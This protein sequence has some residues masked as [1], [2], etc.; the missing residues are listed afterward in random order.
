MQKLGKISKFS[1]IFPQIFERW[2]RC[3]GVH[4][5]DLGERFPKSIYLQ[6][7]PSIQPRTSPSTFGGKIQFNIIQS[8][9]KSAAS[10][11][12]LR[13]PSGLDNLETSGFDSFE[14]SARSEWGKIHSRKSQ[15]SARCGPSTCASSCAVCS[16]PILKQPILKF[17]NFVRIS[18]RFPEKNDVGRFFNPMCEN[19]F[20]NCRKF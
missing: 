3:K 18:R 16:V 15:T 14:A 17:T 20:E 11:H 1:A 9:P 4:C 7:L 12:Q 13:R 19:K 6:N 8:C 10:L 5:V 2:E